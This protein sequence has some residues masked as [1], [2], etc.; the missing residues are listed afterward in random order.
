[1]GMEKLLRLGNVM[2]YP[3]VKNVTLFGTHAICTKSRRICKRSRTIRNLLWELRKIMFNMQGLSK[4]L[5]LSDAIKV[6]AI[7]R[8]VI[9]V[10][11]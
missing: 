10:P 8:I 7:I 11:A 6:L 2:T 4:G 9:W 1:M 5:Q 3:R